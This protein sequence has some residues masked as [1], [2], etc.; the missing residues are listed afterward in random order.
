MCLGSYGAK[1]KEDDR[2]VPMHRWSRK[3]AVCLGCS[4]K[5]FY[6]K[7][8]TLMWVCL[9]TLAIPTFLDIR[10]DKIERGM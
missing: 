10:M 1:N 9:V 8:V 2:T 3:G 7:K 4:L 5:K 6:I